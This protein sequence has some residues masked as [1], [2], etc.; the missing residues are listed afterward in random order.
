MNVNFGDDDMSNSKFV[1][2]WQLITCEYRSTDNEVFYPYGED[3]IGYLTY[4]MDGY[5]SATIMR[6]NRPKL[7]TEDITKVSSEELAMVVKTYLSYCGQYEIQDNQ[8]IHHIQASL[9]PNWLGIAQKRFFNFKDNQL[10]LTSS[11]FLMRGK[12]QVAHM[13]W[14]RIRGTG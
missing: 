1:G 8:V 13:I 3:A 12:Q 10:F 5:M 14:E 6:A 9:F 11:S 7:T 4:T 2:T